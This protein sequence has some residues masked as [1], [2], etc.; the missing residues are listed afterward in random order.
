MNVTH[1]SLSQARSA[2]SRDHVLVLSLDFSLQLR[3]T[4]GVPFSGDN[5]QYIILTYCRS[6]LWV[7]RVHFFFA[8]ACWPLVL[9]L[10]ETHGPTILSKRAKRMRAEGHENAR[11]AHQI[12]KES[13]KQIL[14][15]HILRPTRMCSKKARALFLL[16]Q[17][18]QRCFCMNL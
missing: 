5:Y 18:Q 1:T 4:A 2:L 10:P 16:T 11:A 17:H 12:H 14:Q 9:L 13:R 7:V 3:Q 8:I 15:K 6:G